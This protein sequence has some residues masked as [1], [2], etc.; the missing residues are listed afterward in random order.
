MTVATA[1]S[2]LYFI[3]LVG[4]S[5][6]GGHLE[7]QIQ[8]SVAKQCGV[9]DL[10]LRIDLERERRLI[11]N[12][13]LQVHP[14]GDFPHRQTVGEQV[15]HAAFGDVADSLSAPARHGPAEGDVFDF[16]NQFSAPAFRYDFQSA[17][18]NF[19]LGAGG[20]ETGKD[21]ALRVR[22]DVDEPAAARRQIGLGAEL[23]NVDAAVA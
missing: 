17:V 7:F 3:R 11:E 9:H 4:D 19:E 23:G 1:P 14:G 8:W 22:G 6:M 20:E 16:V 10:E 5:G 12:V 2:T 18:T 13:P 21:N 15:D